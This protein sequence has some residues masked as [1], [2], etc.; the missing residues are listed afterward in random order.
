MATKSVGAEV[1]W[2]CKLL[3]SL[4]PATGKVR[5]SIVTC[6]PVGHRVSRADNDECRHQWLVSTTWCMSSDK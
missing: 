4:L 3:Q 2:C 6:S 5:S 1:T